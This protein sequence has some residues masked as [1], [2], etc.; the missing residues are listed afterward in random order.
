MFH[1]KL[2]H[3]EITGLRNLEQQR[4]AS[5]AGVNIFYGENGAGKTSILEAI[6]LLGLARSFRSTQL[7]PVIQHD[8]SSCT[9][10]G[11]VE[12][13]DYVSGALTL[14]VKRQR[15]G[16]VQIRVGGKP[17]KNAI[18]LAEALPIQ[19]INATS[20]L[21]LEGGPKQRRQFMDWG[22]FHVEQS[23]YD[24]WRN[25]QR[26]IKQRNAILRKGG[27]I[28]QIEPWNESLLI[29]AT[30]LDEARKSYTDK[31]EPVFISIMERLSD[32]GDIRL[33]YRRGW[34]EG[35]YR[36]ILAASLERDRRRGLTHYGP[37]RA[38]LE[39]LAQ[40]HPAAQV[41]SRGQ[42]KLLVC[43][44]RLAQAK[45]LSEQRGKGLVILVDDLPA[46]VDSQHQRRLCALL[47]ELGMQLFLTCIEARELAQFSWPVLG[48]PQLFHVKQG[49][50]SAAAR[51]AELPV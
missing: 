44:L 4:L 42:Q 38:D 40:G 22:V 32:L 6:H 16:G 45:L 47:D 1:V 17:E 18:S 39:I 43:A 37:H 36:D 25:V 31:L 10:F 51:S 28:K 7:T 2:S 30:R 26:C 50:I 48:E 15:G 11:R 13:K 46:E 9:V 35:S 29:S 5:L 24:V 34:K 23:F 8:K 3:L 19:L 21:L 14:G 27:P 12:G 41:L 20:Y 33:Q 49:A